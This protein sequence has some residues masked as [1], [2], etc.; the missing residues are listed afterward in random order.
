MQLAREHR[1]RGPPQ[2][3]RENRGGLRIGDE[4]CDKRGIVALS[5]Q[6]PC[7]HRDEERHPLQPSRQLK[8]PPQG[9]GVRPV[10]I[11][12]REKRRPVKGHVGRE[13]V[14]AVQHRERAL[15]RRA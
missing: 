11:I 3:S 6:R 4:L 7:S 1:D 13:P 10:Q 9:G 14:Q 5:L 2:R 12:D 8:E 15:G